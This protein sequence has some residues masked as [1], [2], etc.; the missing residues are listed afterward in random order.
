MDIAP[1]HLSRQ[2]S[3]QRTLP[4]QHRTA[5][6]LTQEHP[7]V[8]VHAVGR[9]LPSIK[10]HTTLL[11]NEFRDL[12]QVGAGIDYVRTSFGYDKGDQ[13]LYFG[14]VCI[15]LVGLVFIAAMSVEVF[16][17]GRFSSSLVVKKKLNKDEEK[18]NER[19][20]ERTDRSKPREDRSLDVKSQPFTWEKIC[21][22]GG[23]RQLLDSV[24]GFCEPGTL[25]AL[26]GASGAVKTTLLD[27]LRRHAR[28][29][30]SGT[31]EAS[32]IS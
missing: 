1:L 18:L 3:K 23:H 32:Q 9:V 4:T 5:D 6:T 2:R 13:W 12:D 10:H 17:H 28:C 25:T 22:T 20:A 21:Y 26:M 16:E 29:D 11:I 31:S 15:F 7:A 24:E 27:V 14:I 19:L 30:R 8:N